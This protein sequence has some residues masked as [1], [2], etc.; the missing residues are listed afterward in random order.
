MTDEMEKQK[1]KMCGET[2]TQ[3]VLSFDGKDRKG[4]MLT[5]PGAD[6][7]APG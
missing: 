4:G 5:E 6:G 1:D 2:M 7:G 3:G